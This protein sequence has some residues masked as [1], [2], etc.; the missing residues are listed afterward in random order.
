MM[1]D[2]AAAAALGLVGVHRAGRRV[3]EASSVNL[4]A[5]ARA[6]SLLSP[7]C[8]GAAVFYAV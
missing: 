5:M 3:P 7:W 4:T 1:M 6:F 2:L 8:V